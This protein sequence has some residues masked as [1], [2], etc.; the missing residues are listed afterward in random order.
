MTSSNITR[1]KDSGDN[2]FSSSTF[3]W[4]LVRNWMMT[5]NVGL[6]SD[7]PTCCVDLDI[8]PDQLENVQARIRFLF[9]GLQLADLL[10]IN[11]GYA[12]QRTYERIFLIDDQYIAGIFDDRSQTSY[13]SNESALQENPKTLSEL[14]S[15]YSNSERNLKTLI[16]LEK[17]NCRVAISDERCH[18]S[19]FLIETIYP[20]FAAISTISGMVEE[21]KELDCT[22]SF[23]KSNPKTVA[24]LEY[25]LRD[26][27][28]MYQLFRR[29][30]KDPKAVD[31]RLFHETLLEFLFV[32]SSIIDVRMCQLALN[33]S[34][35]KVFQADRS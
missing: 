28:I 5:S 33:G 24:D 2:Q 34:N 7:D 19:R 26:L 6:K 25:S 18:Q 10:K 20:A 21:R 4:N 17:P 3:D 15:V 27:S 12:G 8:G 32:K 9:E 16:V 13:Q 22:S 14:M 35:G 1:L 29:I 31:R 11:G 30:L 23:K